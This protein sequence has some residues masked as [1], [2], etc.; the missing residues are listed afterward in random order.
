MGR[1]YP[2]N[3]EDFTP[4]FN[5]TGNLD[6]D[7]MRTEC[8][9]PAGANV[10]VIHCVYSIIEEDGDNKLV[11]QSFNPDFS[12]LGSPRELEGRQGA[13]KAAL[14]T[15]ANGK[16]VVAYEDKDAEQPDE[17]DV[18][19]QLF[20]RD[21]IA[22]ITPRE[23]NTIRDNSQTGVSVGALKHGGFVVAWESQTDTLQDVYMQVF[24]NEGT[25]L[26]DEDLLVNDNHLLGAQNGPKV[27]PLSTGDFMV[28]WKNGSDGDNHAVSARIFSDPCILGCDDSSSTDSTHSTSDSSN[29]A[30]DSDSSSSS[31]VAAEKSGEDSDNTG[32]I[33]GVTIP[34]VVVLLC[35]IVAGV[36]LVIILRRKR[37]KKA[38]SAMMSPTNEV[39]AHSTRNLTALCPK[40]DL[41]TS[42]KDVEKEKAKGKER[43][44]EAEKNEPSAV[45]EERASADDLEN[46]IAGTSCDI[47][48][49]PEEEVTYLDKKPVASGTFGTIFK[50]RW[51]GK[52]CAVKVSSSV[53]LDEDI[54]EEFRREALIMHQLGGKKNHCVTLFGVMSR[55]ERLCLV[56]EWA[57]Y[58]SAYDLL[59]H[60]KTK[61]TDVPWELVVRIARDTARGLRYLHSMNMVHRDVA[62]RNVLVCKHYK[63]VVGDFGL[64]RVLQKLYQTTRSDLGPVKWMAPE[65]IRH[66]KYSRAT[67]SFSFGVFLWELCTR[68]EPWPGTDALGTAM[69]VVEQGK[70]LPIR[71][72]EDDVMKKLMTKCWAEDPADRPTFQELSSTLEDYYK[73]LKEEAS[74]GSQS[75]VVQGYLLPSFDSEASSSFN[76]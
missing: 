13:R 17:R 3:G 62:A 73:A 58:G 46:P 55:G 15:L 14:A 11:L 29:Q 19:I 18:I 61:K 72:N 64:S 54:K 27:I 31:A 4:I 40:D 75:N 57:K 67:D 56:T 69:A 22:L 59:I 39:Y 10:N 33:V 48:E 2:G 76:N 9:I 43:D 21:G 37:K 26:L 47:L 42:T 66:R 36:V 50:G 23:A 41:K 6:N 12:P 74:H 28:T 5:I 7:N 35:V 52:K 63:A 1:S 25:A 34:L 71:E 51:K 16:W 70:R 38:A 68:Q 44:E 8:V 20:D 60:P 45:V 24:D 32:V 53:V 49:I 30:S 65:A